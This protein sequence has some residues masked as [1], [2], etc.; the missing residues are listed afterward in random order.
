M[1]FVFENQ[2]DQEA[3]T[4]M[5]RGLR[6]TVRAKHSRRSHIF[7]WIVTVLALLLVFWSGENGF[8][9]QL[10]L[11][12][13]FMLIIVAVLVAVLLWEDAINGYVARKRVLPGTQKANV[14]FREDGFTSE[15][16]VGSTAFRYDKIAALAENDH[17][18]IFI[19]SASHA[20]IYDKRRMS[21][22]T[23]DEFRAFIKRMTEK[24]FIKI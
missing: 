9:F 17:Y 16:E 5:A 11:R 18:F 2:Y 4:A 19:Y 15:T 23:P 22:G 6:K 3:M 1:E 7:G 20:Q 10:S 24:Q 14:T 21:G 13:V 8:G 12:S